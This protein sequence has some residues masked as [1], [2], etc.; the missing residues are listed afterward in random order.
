MSLGLASHVE[1]TVSLCNPGKE[2]VR[3]YSDPL[4]LDF[5]NSNT[6]Y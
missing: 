6:E 4:S 2:K 1:L 5:N 3:S